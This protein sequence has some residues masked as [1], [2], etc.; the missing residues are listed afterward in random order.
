M[1]SST[2]TPFLISRGIVFCSR[3]RG[4]FWN[5][6]RS[7]PKSL[8]SLRKSVYLYRMPWHHLVPIGAKSHL[9]WI[10]WPL[11]IKYLWSGVW[12]CLDHHAFPI[13]CPSAIHTAF[14]CLLKL[15]YTPLSEVQVCSWTRHWQIAFV[16]SQAIQPKFFHRNSASIVSGRQMSIFSH[17]TS[18]NRQF[19]K[20]T[21]KSNF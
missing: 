12:S 13:D 9:K 16:M 4:A 14:Q 6:E 15:P 2:V 10:E 11:V 8:K 5:I 20:T 7:S 3:E 19:V 1:I 17:S 21:G 18:N